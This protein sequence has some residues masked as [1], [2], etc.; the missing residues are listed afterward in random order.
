M[1][2]A[3]KDHAEPAA[4]WH[5]QNKTRHL[6][7][8]PP[9]KV[10]V[11]IP[12]YNGANYLRDAISSCLGQSYPNLEVI[13]VNDGSDDHGE[14]EAIAM[15]FTPSIIYLKKKNGG[16]ASALNLALE[17]GSG[18]YFCWLSHD[19]IYLP[20]KVEK[21]I[22]YIINGVDDPCVVYCRHQ[23][24]D[25]N[26]RHLEDPPVP[27]IFDPHT[28]SIQLILGQWL[29]CCTILAPTKLFHQVGGFREDLPTTQDYDI[30][31]KMGLNVPFFEIPEVLLFAR[32]HSEQGSRTLSHRREI[33]TFFREHIPMLSREYIQR[34]LT[35]AESL[36]SF[37]ELGRQM[38]VREM[39]ECVALVCR[40]LIECELDRCETRVI[41][42]KVDQII[43]MADAPDSNALTD[44]M[45]FRLRSVLP[46]YILNK[47]S[48][49]RQRVKRLAASL[50]K[51]LTPTST[52]PPAT[53]KLDFRTIFK[54]NEFLGT[55]SRSGGGSSLF[56]TRIIREEIPRLLHNLGIKTILD[57]PCGDWNWM[58]H[59]DLGDFQYIGGDIVEEIIQANQDRFG[60]VNVRFQKIDIISGPIPK[61]D[62]IL[63]R[64]CLV[65]LSNTDA[66]CALE[67]FRRSGA[68]WL[69]TTTFTGRTENP[70][71]L[72][73]HIW[74][75]LNL[76]LEP[77]LL[78]KSEMAISEG[79]T[80]GNNEYTD[81]SLALWR[82]NPD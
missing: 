1:A 68:K 78:G 47:F 32:Q 43:S 2:S 22:D 36:A 54:N 10:T 71:L 42:E 53:A 8:E 21:Q 29:H 40:Q 15:Q 64:D 6:T 28:A 33:E 41:L 48:A 82:L 49:F 52:S 46:V 50:P 80:E 61:A 20:K 69:L 65:H 75:P 11:A 34:V 56:Q 30:L 51:A 57:A 60:S 9:P 13:V 31:V 74:R 55:E 7:P 62:L 77:F 4:T 19:D 14:T 37:S 35:P 27:P 45:K 18:E 26:G 38:I 17:V 3:P 79:C 81:K 39:P 44:R 73:G 5:A 76:E 70:D 25:A 63:C 59:V 23:S 67:S 58:Q 12:V 24:I 16:V 66:L 72:I